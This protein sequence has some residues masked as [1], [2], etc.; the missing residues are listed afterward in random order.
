MIFS[1][2]SCVGKFS[3]ENLPQELRD[4]FTFLCLF[5]ERSFP[6]DDKMKGLWF[7]TFKS[8]LL[9]INLFQNFYGSLFLV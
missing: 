8:G 2:K 1:R 4:G 9:S 5:N 7:D 6:R 3:T